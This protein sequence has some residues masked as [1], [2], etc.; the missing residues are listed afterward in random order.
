M[1]QA[2]P[3]KVPFTASDARLTGRVEENLI[4]AR[5]AHLPTLR[6]SPSAMCPI[7]L[8]FCRILSV[9]LASS[10]FSARLLLWLAL[11]TSLPFLSRLALV[12]VGWLLLCSFSFRKSNTLRLLVLP[13]PAFASLGARFFRFWEGSLPPF[14][15]RCVICMHWSNDFPFGRTTACMGSIRPSEFRPSPE[16]WQKRLH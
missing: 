6:A 11:Y 15:F 12:S 3:A 5:C 1:K 8:C 10:I 7:S 14:R 13:R 2:P 9:V 16:K 4:I